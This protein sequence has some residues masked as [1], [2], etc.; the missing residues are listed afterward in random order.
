M[1]TWPEDVGRRILTATDSTMA[2]AARRAEAGVPGPE[3]TLALHQTKARGRRGRAWAMPAGNFAASLLM[4]PR[5]TPADA[6]L[7]SFVAAL[8]LREA[9]IAAGWTPGGSPSNGPTTCF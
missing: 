1:S 8:A 5:S 3:W 9:F 2:E 4:R 6:A 7:R